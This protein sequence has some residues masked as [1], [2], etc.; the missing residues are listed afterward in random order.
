MT[1][2]KQP[3]GLSQEMQRAWRI[4]VA[5]LG[6]VGT[7]DP[8]DAQL[9]EMAAMMLGRAREA[10]AEIAKQALEHRQKKRALSHL[11]SE[12]VRGTTSNYLLTVERESIKEFRLLSD[13]LEQRARQRAGTAG[14]KKPGT[15]AEARTDIGSRRRLHSVG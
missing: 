4:I 8:G 14:G 11:M 1:A 10:R 6:R 5:D 12:T 2:L 13:L 9:I 15:L 3:A 7:L